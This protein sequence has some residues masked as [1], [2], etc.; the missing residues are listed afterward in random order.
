MDHDHG[1]TDSRA[2]AQRLSAAHHKV[3]WSILIGFKYS[4]AKAKQRLPCVNRKVTVYVTCQC[5]EKR[6]FWRVID[7]KYQA[8][9]AQF[10]SA[11]YNRIMYPINSLLGLC[12]KIALAVIS[13]ISYGIML[14]LL[15]KQHF[16]V[17]CCLLIET[18]LGTTFHVNCLSIM[19]PFKLLHSW[20]CVER[21]FIA[22]RLQLSHVII[23][24]TTK[25]K[26]HFCLRIQIRNDISCE[27]SDGRRFIC[28]IKVY[29]LP[30]II[31]V[32]IAICHD[33]CP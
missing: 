21:S 9:G 25:N 7:H 28:N 29:F 26:Q 31:K 13:H 32:Y 23:K 10:Y 15:N 22:F 5:S 6:C 11:A 33:R 12:R 16:K 30:N 18:N 20:V 8:L 2:R 27:L 24:L 1:Q 17:C 19:Y 3:T 4:T 14:T